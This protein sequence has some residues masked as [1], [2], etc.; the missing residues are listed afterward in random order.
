MQKYEK[1]TETTAFALSKKLRKICAIVSMIDSLT[2]KRIPTIISD[3]MQR[4]KKLVLEE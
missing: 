2:P 3:Y 4:R 1:S